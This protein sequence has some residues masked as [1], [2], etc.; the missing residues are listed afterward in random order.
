MLSGFDDPDTHMAVLASDGS[1]LASSP[2]FS[3]LGMTQ[4]TLLA[5]VKAVARDADQLLK[6]PVPTGRGYLPAAIGKLSDDPALHLLFCVETA[7][8]QMDPTNDDTFTQ[9]AEAVSDGHAETNVPPDTVSAEAVSS[10]D[11]NQLDLNPHSEIAFN[12]ALDAVSHIEDAPDEPVEQDAII[13][14]EHNRSQPLSEDRSIATGLQMLHGEF[15]DDMSLSYANET[16]DDLADL[17]ALHALDSTPYDGVPD[18]HALP[19]EFEAEFQA[20]SKNDLPD[21]QQLDPVSETDEGLNADI[22]SDDTVQGDEPSPEDVSTAEIGSETTEQLD[23]DRFDNAETEASESA[24]FAALPDQVEFDPTVEAVAENEDQLPPEVTVASETDLDRVSVTANDTDP[25]AIF[26]QEVE[27][28]LVVSSGTSE[29]TDSDAI[30]DDTD[31]EVD[32]H[33]ETDDAE[34]EGHD[35]VIAFDE[36]AASADSDV[37]EPEPMPEPVFQFQ[38]NSRPVRFVWKVDASGKFSEIS[39]EFAQAVGPRAAAINDLYFADVARAFKMDPDGKI[40]DL[41]QKRDTWSG[42]TIFWP[43]E[44]TSLKVPVDL[45]ALPTY[46]RSRS[47][48]GFRGFGIVRLVDAV[49]DADQIGIA[50]SKL[51]EP[52]AAEPAGE[53]SNTTETAAED[54]LRLDAAPEGIEAENSALDPE[55][56]IASENA[57]IVDEAAPFIDLVSEETS[58]DGVEITTSDVSTELEAPSDIQSDPSA[59]LTGAQHLS[60]ETHETADSEQPLGL[61]G[62]ENNVLEEPLSSNGEVE[63]TEEHSD[64]QEL[65][66]S[67]LSD[68]AAADDSSTDEVISEEV[69]SADTVVA[70]NANTDEPV[71]QNRSADG[72]ILELDISNTDETDGTVDETNDGETGQ[73][74]ETTS[75]SPSSDNNTPAVFDEFHGETPALRIVENPGRR[76]SDKVISIDAHRGKSREGLSLSEQAAFQEI[77]RQLD[78]LGKRLPPESQKDQSNRVDNAPG[79][80]TTPVAPA[81][82]P[83]DVPRSEPAVSSDTST[84]S[85]LEDQ[86]S[87][88]IPSRTKSEEQL[89]ASFVDA[90]PLAILVHTGENLIHANPEFFRVTGYESLDQLKDYGGLDALLERDQSPRSPD[91]APA[92]LM[93]TAHGTLEPVT[94]RLQSI[95][96]EDSHAL[97]LALVPKRAESEREAAAKAAA[98]NNHFDPEAKIKALTIEVDELRSILETA[99]DGV[100]IVGQDGDIRSMNKSASALFNFDDEDT[101]GKSFAMLFAH[102]SQK[103]VMDYLSGLSGHGVASV[104][105]DGRE[106]IGR[107]ASGGFIPLFMT[108]G[109]LSSSNG[110]CAVIRDITQWKRTEEEL[111]TAKRAAETANAHKSEF[112][113]RVSHE[114][115]TPLNAII[116]FSDMMATERLGPIGHPRYVEYSDDIGRSGRHVL[117]IV[118]DLLDISR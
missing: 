80:N 6:R 23:A 72:S 11:G 43:V 65:A 57:E 78:P 115:R 7:I 53:A 91:E 71:E 22:V 102:E 108:M 42:K 107:E 87:A 19:T 54:V 77:A 50:L 45:A 38:R 28:T 118:N 15:E 41:L 29:D 117:D 21:E 8:G 14:S 2:D 112:L 66:S 61:I 62:T 46:S 97:L 103:A 76:L 96:W 90:L 12:E 59:D 49:E 100:V 73:S 70:E 16:A 44:G 110:Y 79:S 111:R 98:E 56:E 85:A 33:V 37:P 32:A 39:E 9:I 4:E 18:V 10:N 89:S 84:A 113:A 69:A 101:R 40:G 5:F 67:S 109:R 31:S 68:V 52:Q 26:V 81:A 36:P 58:S 74:A 3:N 116:G 17:S 25:D 94:A 93:V 92:M 86:V 48:D 13:E 47:F 104:L 1:V 64:E 30:S 83:S 27:Q 35:A 60:V 51:D 20:F 34:E 63:Q 88:L 114:I 105:N 95:R 75:G 99:T 106:V 55:A 24:T 82:S